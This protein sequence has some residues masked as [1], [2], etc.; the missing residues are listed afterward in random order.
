[1]VGM[2]GIQPSEF[3][4]MTLY[5]INLAIKGFREY[6]SGEKEESIGSEEFEKLKDMFP[7]Y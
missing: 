4:D 7:D 1:M 2:M 5:E 6:N 3:W